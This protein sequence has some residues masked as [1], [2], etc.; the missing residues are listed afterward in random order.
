MT[1]AAIALFWS[2]PYNSIIAVEAD[3]AFL[4]VW[5][6]VNHGR[7]FPAELCPFQLNDSERKILKVYSSENIESYRRRK[8]KSHLMS[9]DISGR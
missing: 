2:Y 1:T 6:N 9:F 4:I 3:A 8:N 7:C 5:I